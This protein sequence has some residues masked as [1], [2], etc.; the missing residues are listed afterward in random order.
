MDVRFVA[1][2]AV[3]TTDAARDRS[4]FVDA[5]GLPLRPAVSPP[6]SDYVYSEEVN[7][8][9]HLGVWPLSEAAQACFGR[10]MWPDTHPQPQASIEFEVDDVESAARELVDRGYRLLHPART[11]PWQQVIA[12]LQAVDGLLVGVCSTPW[13]HED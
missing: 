10:R 7:G 9:K 1:S 5:L 11:E 4:L 13:L 6:D 3:I 12:R 8:A 2:F